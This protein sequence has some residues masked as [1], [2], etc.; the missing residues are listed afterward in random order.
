MS[1]EQQEEE[2]E[3][4][5]PSHDHAA[6]VAGKNYLPW[7]VGLAEII[8]KKEKVKKVKIFNNF[9]KHRNN[10]RNQNIEINA[11]NDNKDVN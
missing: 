3:H 6:K 9:S 10:Y 8:L 5:N 4:S 1:P 11:N 2:E 7:G